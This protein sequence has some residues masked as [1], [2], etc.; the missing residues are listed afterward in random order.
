MNDSQACRIT[1]AFDT[2]HNE[3]RRIRAENLSL[4]A[5]AS[6][7]QAALEIA[8]KELADAKWQVQQLRGA[9]ARKFGAVGVDML[10]TMKATA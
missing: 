4:R 1:E 9:L 2:I 8:Q 3:V 10:P 7:A 6:Q 5:K